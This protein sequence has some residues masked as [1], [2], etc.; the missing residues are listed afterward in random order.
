MFNALISLIGIPL[1]WVMWVL[2]YVV[3][4]Y[5]LALLLFTIFSRLIMLPVTINQQKSTAK[6]TMLRPQLE[7]I[8]KKYANNRQKLNEEMMA[9]YTRENYNPMSGCLP[10]IVQFLILFG[11]IDVIYKPLKHILRLPAVFIQE[12]QDLLPTISQYSARAMTSQLPIVRE[13]MQNP[14][15]FMNLS[16][17]AESV[18]KVQEFASNL[19]FMGIDLIGQPET[20]MFFDLFK[21]QFNPVILIPVLSGITSLLLSINTLKSTSATTEGQAG[22][23]SIK[24]MMLTMPIFS[25][26]FTFSV[27][28]GVGLYWT[29]SNVVGLLQNLVVYKFYNPKEMAEKAQREYEERKERERQERIEAKKRAL[30]QGDQ[31]EAKALSKKEQNRRKLA[32]ARRRDAEKY[33]EVYEEVTD[34]DL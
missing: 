7:E 13:I 26:L 1:G 4:N 34:D 9:L 14:N 12:A 21:G 33:G 30:E 31:E 8:Q 10:M 11:I 29:F 15:P 27:P 5:G 32:E 20:S 25:V 18:A 6:M 2:Y 23:G 19:M 22:A 17:G 28:A 24:A 3:K 16:F